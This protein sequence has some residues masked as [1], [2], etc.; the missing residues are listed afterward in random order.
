MANR[1]TNQGGNPSKA[2]QSSLD[3][4]QEKLNAITTLAQDQILVLKD[5]LDVVK[6]IAD[7]V[8]AGLRSKDIIYAV[9]PEANRLA[10]AEKEREALRNQPPPKPDPFKSIKDVFDSLK[11]AF[12]FVKVLLI[13][14]MIGFL[15]GFRKKFDLL[16]IAIGA[17]I[18]WPIRTF[19]LMVSL[20]KNIISLVKNIG[21]NVEYARRQLSIGF[22]ML[23][24]AWNRTFIA[25]ISNQFLSSIQGFFSR[26]TSKFANITGIT[27]ATEKLTKFLSNVK[28]LFNSMTAPIND[29]IRA[30]AALGKFGERIQKIGNTFNRMRLAVIPAFDKFM[31]AVNSTKNFFL[32]IGQ[33]I[34]GIFSKV[35]TAIKPVTNFI[36][37]IFEPI[38]KL[39][40]AGSGAAGLMNNP[41]MKFL[42][43]IAGK[44]L[45]AVP[46]LGQIIMIVEGLMGLV[47]GG[48]KGYEEGG[49]IGAIKGALSGL[50]DGLFGWIFDLVGWVAGALG[51]EDA[52]KALEEYGLGDLV[53]DLLGFIFDPIEKV[54][55]I[56]GDVFT[57]KLG[58]VEGTLKLVGTFLDGIIAFP[59]F[60]LEAFA[61]IFEFDAI[62]EML[63][64]FSFTDLFEQL[65]TAIK[66]W[67]LDA[68]KSLVTI[69]G[70]DD[71]E[72]IQEAKDQQAIQKAAEQ[73]RNTDKD[74]YEDLL[75]ADDLEEA[76][77]I[78]ADNGYNPEQINNMLGIPPAK[79]TPVPAPSPQQ[80]K[81]KKLD[82]ATEQQAT[83]AAAPKKEQQ[84]GS[85]V[86]IAVDKSQKLAA[87][88]NNL[89]RAEK[90]NR[91]GPNV[92][93]AG[94]FG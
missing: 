75:D 50:I 36:K 83:L 31:D 65:W 61:G 19:K 70:G 91:G 32:G 80:A 23:T 60:L 34:S 90:P 71:A 46:I 43:K 66:K 88:Y 8:V 33:K 7:N 53:N 44:G 41:A 4:Q 47:K 86:N 89:I 92:R 69:G 3:I 20:F 10:D 14:L 48:I 72:D 21:P 40:R 12:D 68:A 67:V 81:K 13:P 2:L 22:R 54:F 26:L 29:V 93:S 39:F 78:L 64:E 62:A 6:N 25:R 27:K 17:A 74:L 85:K 73:F 77:E 87:T 52:E 76:K 24:N 45:K 51:F 18:L 11:K 94:P 42:F 59:K 82:E 57:G 38:T 55:G 1:P 9:Q 16:T 35:M 15:I 56:I 5:I 30:K 49:I 63:R 84:S 28:I 79:P 37:A 58:I